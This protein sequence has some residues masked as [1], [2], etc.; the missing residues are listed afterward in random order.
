MEK[1]LIKTVNAG[2]VNGMLL[3]I[4]IVAF[5]TFKGIAYGETLLILEVTALAMVLFYKI[6]LIPVILKS[7]VGNNIPK[8][9]VILLSTAIYA[10]TFKLIVISVFGFFN[11]VFLKLS[12]QYIINDFP[13]YNVYLNVIGEPKYITLG[14]ISFFITLQAF[15]MILKSTRNPV[16]KVNAKQTE[17]IIQPAENVEPKFTF[18]VKS[19]EEILRERAEREKRQKEIDEEW[20]RQQALRA[21]AQRP[22]SQINKVSSEVNIPKTSSSTTTTKNKPSSTNN[23]SAKV[24]R[25]ARF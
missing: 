12:G 7:K 20:R 6:A 15:K 10:L 8:K 21:Q 17:E 9:T 22:P 3:S 18:D 1:N 23:N 25:R 24:K 5:C 19:D 2:V 11:N 4:I 13:D 14:V 16:E